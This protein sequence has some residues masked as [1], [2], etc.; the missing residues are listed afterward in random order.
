[1][2]RPYVGKQ[3]QLCTPKEFIMKSEIWLMRVP[4]GWTSTW[5]W[6]TSHGIHNYSTLINNI[7]KLGDSSEPVR[8]L[9]SKL[10]GPSPLWGCI[11]HQPTAN[12]VQT[13]FDGSWTD[14]GSGASISS[15]KGRTVNYWCRNYH[16]PALSY[17]LI[18]SIGIQPYESVPCN[19]L[20]SN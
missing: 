14:W 7:S 18:S 15:L 5:S 16:N 1:M 9:N 3:F 6:G 13:P 2:N 4:L 20:Q 12:F 17:A 19:V 8:M 11:I 10:D